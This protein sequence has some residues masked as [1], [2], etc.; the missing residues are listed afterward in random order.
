MMTATDMQRT[1]CTVYMFP[2]LGADYPD[3]LQAFCR[4][5]PWAEALIA[6]WENQIGHALLAD[7]AEAPKDRERVRQLRIHCQNL[8]WWRLQQPDT[9][10]PVICCG[11][12]LGFYAALVAA[13]AL[14][15]EASWF[16]L[17]TVFE[18]AWQAFAEHRGHIAVLTTTV[19]FD[20]YRL[21]KQ[22]S[23]EVIARNSNQQIVIH[24]RPENVD[25]MCRALSWAS[26]RRSEL[27]TTLPF[28]SIEMCRVAEALA[29]LGKQQH[30]TFLM[31]R[32]QVWSHLSGNALES[33]DAIAGA[34][35]EQ[36]MRTVNWQLLIHN[37]SQH[38]QPNFVEIG[39]NRILSQ[40]VRWTDPSAQVRHVDHIRKQQHQRHGETV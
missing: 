35:L 17:A 5:Y 3:M 20:P 4:H 13:G 10:K 16:W 23:V 38:F 7:A 9:D 31:P 8:L 36:P 37:L 19:A 15:E 1:P 25:A 22:F 39:P 40:L 34:L 21:A 33:T 18:H 32:H 30:H 2:G 12:S 24:G 11:H 27:G 29:Q 6:D 28:H 26:L 14:T